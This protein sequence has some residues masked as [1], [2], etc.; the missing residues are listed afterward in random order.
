MGESR[1]TIEIMCILLMAVTALVRMITR[2]LVAQNLIFEQ[3]DTSARNSPQLCQPPPQ[4][5][6]SSQPYKHKNKHTWFFQDNSE[7]DGTI[8]AIYE[9]YVQ[10]VRQAPSAAMV[11]N[12][13]MVGS[14]QKDAPVVA[15]SIEPRILLNDLELTRSSPSVTINTLSESQVSCLVEREH[16]ESVKPEFPCLESQ[17]GEDPECDY[18]QYSRSLLLG[19]HV[20]SLRIAK[21]PP[22]LE[23]EPEAVRLATAAVQLMQ[24]LVVK[25]MP[26]SRNPSA[27]FHR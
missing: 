27:V 25:A 3:Q 20:V 14:E 12:V 8:H 23:N 9:E 26:S 4:R 7:S 19:H 5:R 16:V 10:N 15:A 11:K 21:G 17:D 6:R 13:T 24:P 2:F 1:C 22:G 18:N